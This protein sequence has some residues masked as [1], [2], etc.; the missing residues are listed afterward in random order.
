MKVV[1]KYIS[2][3]GLYEFDSKEECYDYELSQDTNDDIEYILNNIVFYTGDKQSWNI[4]EQIKS[5]KLEGSNADDLDSLVRKFSTC[6]YIYV[7][8][9]KIFAIAAR[10][11]NKSTV[12]ELIYTFGKEVGTKDSNDL[13][14]IYF[15]T[16]EDEWY[17]GSSVVN[18][19]NSRILDLNKMYQNLSINYN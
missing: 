18:E 3:D 1:S 9:K 2:N 7:R 13:D 5:K 14:E 12:A 4:F 16:S 6:D 15:K 8:N 19:L 17:S 10:Q 11:R